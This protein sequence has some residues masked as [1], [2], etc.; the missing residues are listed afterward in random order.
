MDAKCAKCNGVALYGCNLCEIL[1]C[2]TCW[3]DVHFIGTL[4]THKPVAPKK[5]GCDNKNCKKH[6]KYGLDL[7]CTNLL[8]QNV[9]EPICIL[10]ERDKKH[11]NCKCDLLGV[12]AEEKRKY[13]HGQFVKA[14]NKH[15]KVTSLI[16]KNCEND[17]NN[18]TQTRSSYI[19]KIKNSTN[20]LRNLVDK[21]ERKLVGNVNLITSKKI[22]MINKYKE[23]LSKISHK[24]GDQYC[25]AHKLTKIKDDLA[26]MD[27]FYEDHIVI[28]TDDSVI[29]NPKFN[30]D[31]LKGELDDVQIERKIYEEILD[32]SP[33]KLFVT[34]EKMALQKKLEAEFEEENK[35]VICELV[36]AD[37]IIEVLRM[38]IE[39]LNIKCNTIQKSNDELNETKE[40]FN[41]F[42]K[43]IKNHYYTLYNTRMV[44][45]HLISQND[46]QKSTLSRQYDA[47]DD[48]LTNY[49]KMIDKYNF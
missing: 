47:M 39:K 40:D 14:Y 3:D 30:I 20:N 6:T 4:T 46:P 45:W 13:A 19:T 28:S 27:K 29:E 11:N 49:N 12:V 5:L 26:F 8:C 25:T 37:R 38:E 21:I 32:N 31:D 44:A 48:I 2:S 15:V 1:L 24:T 35:I 7:V 33:I 42:N 17:M 36:D 16:N 18:V 9:W 10:C 23:E 43:I 34:E 41:N 22:N